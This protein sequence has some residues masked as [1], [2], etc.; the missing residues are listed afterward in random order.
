MAI[1]NAIATQI[2]NGEYDLVLTSG[3]P[4]MQ[5]VA[6]AN[7]EGRTIHVFGVTAIR[8]APASAWTATIPFVTHGTSSGRETAPSH[9]Q[10]QDREADVS[11][12]ADG[13]RRLEPGGVELGGL[14]GNGPCGVSRARD[15]PSGDQRRQHVRRA[16]CRELAGRARSAGTVDRRRQRHDVGDRYALLAARA[17]GSPRSPSRRGARIAERLWMSASTSSRS[18]DSRVRWRRTC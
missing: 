10:F 18:G 16:R 11:R 4:S 9:R 17:R 1:G 5:A 14:Y 8:S 12:S 6:R 3:T 13:R 2:T 7:R 15:H